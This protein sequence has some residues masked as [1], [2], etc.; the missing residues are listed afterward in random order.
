MIRSVL[1]RKHTFLAKSLDDY[2]VENTD[3]SSDES[4]ENYKVE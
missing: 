4:S 3:Q 2:D 1:G